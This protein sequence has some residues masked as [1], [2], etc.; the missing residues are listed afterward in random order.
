MATKQWRGGL[1]GRVRTRQWSVELETGSVEKARAVMRW[2]QA[3]ARRVDRAM[4]GRVGKGWAT[5]MSQGTGSTTG[6]VAAG[7]GEWRGCRWADGRMDTRGSVSRRRRSWAE[8]PRASAWRVSQAQAGASAGAMAG[9][10]KEV[11]REGAAV[12]LAST[13]LEELATGRAAA[14]ART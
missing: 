4:A 14:G 11:S 13:A 1:G 6:G 9:T 10:G 2:R 8:G 7:N 3:Q 12:S 5:T